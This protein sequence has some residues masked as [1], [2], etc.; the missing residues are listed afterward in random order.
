VGQHSTGTDIVTVEVGT[1]HQK[2]PQTMDSAAG[3][4]CGAG[5]KVGHRSLP[6]D[7]P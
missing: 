4:L 6:P 7:G 2:V 5:L 3:A 1:Q